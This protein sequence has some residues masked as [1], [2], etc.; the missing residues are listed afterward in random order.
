MHASLHLPAAAGTAYQKKK[1]VSRYQ[2]RCPHNTIY[3]LHTRIAARR[4]KALIQ[5]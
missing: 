5:P 1:I 2:H 4:E 3:A